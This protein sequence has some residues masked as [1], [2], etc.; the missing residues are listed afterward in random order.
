MK[1]VMEAPILVTCPRGLAPVLAAEVAGL[2]LSV[3]ATHETAVETAGPLALCRRL[4][5]HLRTGHRVLW[6]LA[7]FGATSA[8]DVYARCA[9]M[10]WEEVLLPEHPITV[11]ASSD[12]VDAGPGGR[13]AALKC[14]DAIADRMRARCGRRPDSGPEPRGACVFILWRDGD[15]RV[16]LDTTG[17]PLSFRGYRRLTV[18]APMRES[19][20]AGVV[21]A[22]GWRGG[23]PF[24][25]PMCGSG[26]LAIEA[27]WIAQRRAPGLLRARFAFQCLR[28]YDAAAWRAERD[29]AL[30][31]VCPSAGVSIVATDR[32]AAAVEAARVNSRAA[33]V[34]AAIEFAA[35]DFMETIVPGPAPMIV[36]NPEY[37][38]RM[39]R[40]TDLAAEYRRIGRFL[41]ERGRG[42]RG[43]VFTGNL[44]LSRRIGLHVDRI[45]TMYNG[46]IEC[47]MLEFSLDGPQRPGPG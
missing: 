8:N 14:K 20:A 10:P 41:R 11:R 34:E 1:P 45:C 27:A 43:V 47:R 31:A 26:T 23:T 5:L 9:A 37:G 33:G 2:G 19:L 38:E 6:R 28:G 12:A 13:V 4:N 21:L 17:V 29:E 32:D 16:F 24:V 44:A 46:P 7:R 40:D 15:C 22:S 25:N 18:E 42:G 3:V 36:L 35:C 39:G 30:G